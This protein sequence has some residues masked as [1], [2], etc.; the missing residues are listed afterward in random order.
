[1]TARKISC[2]IRCLDKDTAE[3]ART[4][5][6]EK[7]QTIVPYTCKISG[8]REEIVLIS[9]AAAVDLE[10]KIDQVF[11]P[12]EAKI[13]AALSSAEL[14]E[15]DIAALIGVEETRVTASLDRMEQ[16]ELVQRR[17][18]HGM[19]YFTLADGT[20]KNALAGRLGA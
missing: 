4:E 17:E 10:K 13:G 19:N 20:L 14:C 3:T 1:M 12:L 2:S 7:A 18:L 5:M 8:Q 9:D 11:S 16:A 6:G 15:C